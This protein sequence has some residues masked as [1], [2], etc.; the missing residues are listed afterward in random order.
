MKLKPLNY[1]FTIM[2]PSIFLIHLLFIVKS[3]NA[4]ED[5]AATYL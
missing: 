2:H 1:T 3:N 5:R 4:C